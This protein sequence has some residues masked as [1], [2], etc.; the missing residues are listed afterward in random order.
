[1][2]SEWEVVPPT[3]S[4]EA[5]FLEIV[6]DFGDPLELLREA[7]SNAIDAKA[8][9]FR[10]RFVVRELAGAAR[11]VIELEDNGEGMSREILARDF[12][13]LGF[14]NSRNRTDAIGEKGHGTKI[15]L[16]SQRVEV[17]TQS[18]DGAFEAMCESPLEA[19]STHRLHQP[20]LR[21][22]VP[23][24]ESTGTVIRIVGYN[25]NERSRFRQDIIR[26]YLRWFTKLGSVELPFGH[27]R[28]ASF[29]VYLQALDVNDSELLSFGHHFPEESHDIDRL[30]ETHGVRA[31]DQYVKRFLFKDERLPNHPEI[32]FDMI[33]SV[34]G[35]DIKRAYNPMIR[36]RSHS[37]TGK[38]RV[39]DR[40]G[41]WLC[42][43]FIPIDRVNEWIT[44]FGTGSNAFV[45]LH[46]FVN[47]QKLKLTANRKSIAN[48]DA[49]V[50]ED[51]RSA[52]S[53]KIGEVDSFL[54]KRGLYTLR[55]WQEEDRTNQQETAEF[56]RRVKNLKARRVAVLDG[57]RLLAPINESELFGLFIALHSLKPG[58]FPFEPL[59]YNTTR[60]IDVIAR[61]RSKSPIT[62]GE[63]WYVELKHTLQTRFN[64]SFSHIRYVLCWDFDRNIGEGTEFTGVGTE[65]RRLRV[66]ADA[67]GRKLYF[68]DATASPKRIEVIRLNEYLKD[69][70][71]LE[72]ELEPADAGS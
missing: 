22:I 70:V 41:V 58:L 62:E 45:L 32:A 40:Y 17:Q 60:G 48:T 34:E 63:R 33:V 65:V 27:D 39:A 68:L 47:C 15:F 59:D 36:E 4:A 9:E 16:R 14:S 37:Q 3:V 69:H 8:S 72:F 64:H 31:A 42:K 23:F 25:D 7:L 1:M 5:E 30:F 29:K 51:L 49:R 71:G 6:N 61:N 2:D 21:N 18:R 57:R 20:K 54:Q 26:D 55:T 12:W 13:G 53:Q 46:A 56:E 38:Y 35:D 67:A 66:A 10:I 19:L 52:V 50:L 24:R 44:G 11:L 43:D 28:L